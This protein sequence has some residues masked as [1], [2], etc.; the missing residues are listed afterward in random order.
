MKVLKFGGTSVGNAER[1]QN[2]SKI[3]Q[4]T[5]KEVDKAIVVVSAIAGVTDQLLSAANAAV[6]NEAAAL[7]EIKKIVLQ[8][9]PNA[10]VI[11]ST[12]P[13]SL[14]LMPS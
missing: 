13:R 2:V 5:L 3:I 8:E 1:I 4:Q 14:S 10:E 11:F 6:K 12:Q 7:S 9:E